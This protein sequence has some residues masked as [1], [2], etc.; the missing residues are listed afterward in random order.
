MLR[1]VIRS[2][3]RRGLW[4]RPVARP[5]WQP[6][7]YISM[8]APLSREYPAFVRTQT[9]NTDSF[10][11][12]FFGP[13]YALINLFIYILQSPQ[14]PGIQSDLALMEV[15]AGYFARVKFATGS[16][17]SI[18]FAREM[19]TLAREA[20]ERACGLH[21]GSTGVAYDQDLSR[22]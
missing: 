22:L 14:R 9:A 3:H 2:R 16:E 4:Q 18:S 5:F 1:C 13:M 11:L 19:A 10:R 8:P 17:I 21:T 12:S 15:G 7:S 20:A 6:N